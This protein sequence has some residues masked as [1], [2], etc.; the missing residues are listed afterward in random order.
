MHTQTDFL[1][2]FVRRAKLLL[3]S[4]MIIMELQMRI[5]QV[6]VMTVWSPPPSDCLLRQVNQQQTN[7]NSWLIS[8]GSQRFKRQNI[9]KP[10]IVFVMKEKVH[11]R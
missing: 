3:L 9:Y 7:I 8:E 10:C 5:E 1:G 2:E 6:Q 4:L 11:W